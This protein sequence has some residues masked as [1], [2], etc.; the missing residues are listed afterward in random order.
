MPWL[1]NAVL[2]QSR[3]RVTLTGSSGPGPV[4]SRLRSLWSLR[5]APRA[6]VQRVAD[7][8]G[9]GRSLAH[10]AGVE[11]DEP[12]Q[13]P[14]ERQCEFHGPVRGDVGQLAGYLTAVGRIGHD[15]LPLR[16]IYHRS[17]ACGCRQGALAIRSRGARLRQP[18]ATPL[19]S[20]GMAY[21]CDPVSSPKRLAN[22]TRPVAL[23]VIASLL[24]GGCAST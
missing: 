21:V 9:L 23:S 5:R 24:F 13:E 15:A 20:W 17:R 18:H 7:E 2:S 12:D 19:L 22:V 1:G 4:T 10:E 3:I 11:G 6:L 8:D 16:G 14:R